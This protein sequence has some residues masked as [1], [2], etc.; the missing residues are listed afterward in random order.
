MGYPW[1]AGNVLT[2]T[3]LNSALAAKTDLAL[4]QSVKT[5]DY[6]FAKADLPNLVVAN[7]A[8]AIV[9]TLPTDATVSTWGTGSTIKFLNIGAGVLTIT[10]AVGVTINA[11]T[12]FA[13]SKGGML[14][15]SAANTWTLV[16]FSGGVDRATYSATT[17]SP[18]ITTVAGKTCIKWTG[19]GSVTTT[20]GM[21]TVLLVGG[22]SGGG[23][24]TSTNDNNRGGG[25]GGGAGGYV[26]YDV[27]FDDSG[28]WPVTVGAGGGLE[29]VGNASAVFPWVAAEG[30]GNGGRGAS[31]AYVGD[32]GSGGGA[33]GWAAGMRTAGSARSSK[34]GNSGV[35]VSSDGGGGGGKGAAPTTRTGGVGQASSITGSSVTYA[36]GG[37][38]GAV[39][40]SPLAGAAN[41]GNGGD[42]GPWSGGVSTNSGAAGGSGVVILVFG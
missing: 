8:T 26:A 23:Y 22:G 33:G 32:G 3:D 1:S 37:T 40:S 20:A 38:G 15:W 30:G 25:G 41:T 39:G 4:T 42:G 29:A 21:V 12:T 11:N 16:P 9:F 19:S 5:G 24:G 28:T 6:T 35:A 7:K 2:A 18:T 10:A 36:A 34:M 31:G 17:G 13:T 14:V 27:Y